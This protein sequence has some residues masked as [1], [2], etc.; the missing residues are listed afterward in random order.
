MFSQ[1]DVIHADGIMGCMDFKLRTNAKY[2]SDK[3]LLNDLKKAAELLGKQTIGQREYVRL[4]KFSCKP[5]R[6]RFGSWNKA[7]ARAGLKVE[8]V[9]RTSDQE[10]FDKRKSRV[11]Q[12]TSTEID[13]KITSDKRETTMTSSQ[14][15]SVCLRYLWSKPCNAYWRYFTR[16]SC[17][18]VF[19]G[20]R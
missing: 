11:R 3:E 19:K 7:L 6:N 1:K 5:Y 16:R 9:G 17:Y 8:K 2:F 15:R 14:E 20:W 4:G 10:L 12:A 18:P 13:C